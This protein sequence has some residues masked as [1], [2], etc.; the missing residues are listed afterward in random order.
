MNNPPKKKSRYKQGVFVPK[1][2]AK[3]QG[4]TPIVYR[5]SW[6]LRVMRWFDGNPSI[7][8]WASESLVIPYFFEYDNKMHRYYVDFLARMVRRDGSQATFAI[9]VKPYKETLPPTTRKRERLLTE[10][11]TYMKNQAKWAAAKA[12]CDAKGITF[13][14]LTEKD[15][16]I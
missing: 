9:E 13:I 3:Y 2:P 8:L 12:F 4:T 15:L 16:N 10:S 6:E 11:E 7:M 1:N 14:V 5:S